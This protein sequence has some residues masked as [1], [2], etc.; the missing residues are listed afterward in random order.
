MPT[1]PGQPSGVL[2]CVHKVGK[3]PL[4]FDYRTVEITSH[5]IS[6][7]TMSLFEMPRL[8]NIEFEYTLPLGRLFTIIIIGPAN[9]HYRQKVQMVPSPSIPCHCLVQWSPVSTIPGQPSG[10]LCCVHEVGGTLL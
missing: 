6:I 8:I 9:E 4:N 3:K 5:L 7:Y 10:S 2:C 1:V